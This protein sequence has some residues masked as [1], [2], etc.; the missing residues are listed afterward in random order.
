MFET[1]PTWASFIDVVN[2]QYYPV[3]NY[4]DHYRKWTI[5]N[6]ERDQ[7]VLEYTKNIHTLRTNPG[8]RDSERNM[9]LKYHSILRYHIQTEMELLDIYSIGAAYW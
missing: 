3:G 8:I 2:E 4:D 7:A 1:N 6:Q 5:F 9:V